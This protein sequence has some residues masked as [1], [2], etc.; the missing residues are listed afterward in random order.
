[1]E[2]NTKTFLV[3]K[4]W[5]SNYCQTSNICHTLVD[6]TIVDNSVVVG[7]A[8]TGDAPITSSFPI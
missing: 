5:I 1:M 3:K 6:N 2:W 7:A 8:P 4:S